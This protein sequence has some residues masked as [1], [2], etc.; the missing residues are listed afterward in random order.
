MK[1]IC[2]LIMVFLLLI[3]CALAECE[4]AISIDLLG[5]QRSRQP[6]QMTQVGELAAGGRQQF[7]LRL[8]QPESL[9]LC[10]P[11]A[12]APFN[13]T[14]LNARVNGRRLLPYFAFGG[15]T[16]YDA[17]KG[18][19]G[20]RP[21]LPTIEGRWVIPARWLRAD[22]NE[23]IIWTTGVQRDAALERLGPAPTIRIDGITIRPLDGANL[24]R[25][26]NSVYYDFGI[27][28]S[29]YPVGGTPERYNYDRA[30]LGMINGEGM[31]EL[32][33]PLDDQKSLWTTK[34]TC[35]DN[36]LGWGY[37]H[38]E[39]YTI[40]EFATKPQLWAKFIDV[41]K[42][43]E[44]TGELH[45]QTVGPE[46]T[47]PGAD[48]VLFDTE[49]YLASLEPAIRLLSPY[50]DFYDFKCEQ[51]GPRAHGFGK[52]GEKL[53]DNGIH[54]DMWAR[55]HYEANKA[56][57][58]LVR[59]YNPDDGFIQE[60][61]H[62]RQG[63]RP[64]LYD[65]ALKRGQPMGDLIDILSLSYDV[66]EENDRGPDGLSIPENGSFHLQYPSP[67]GLEDLPFRGDG[68]QGNRYPEV[69]ID[70][71]RYRLS[72]TEQ[73]MTLGDPKVNHWGN[74]R[75][76]D[77]RAGLR[78]DEMMYTS[79]NGVWWSGYCGSTTYQF[80]QGFFSY[81]L[82][83]TGA[84]EPR[85]MKITKRKSLLET[86][87]LE[88][89]RYGE[90]VNGAGNTKRLRTV[91]PLYGDLF[92]MTGQEM[93]GMRDGY[94]GSGF[95]SPN[96]RQPGTDAF[97]L[98]RRTCYAFMTTGPIVPVQANKGNSDQLFVKGL[99]QTFNYQTYIGIYA[100]N[101]G[102][103]A[104]TLNVTL[105]IAFPDGAEAIVYND[106]AWD[107]EASARPMSIPAGQEFRYTTKVPPLSA[108]LVLIPTSTD[109]LAA[110]CDLPAAPV[111]LSPEPDALLAKGRPTFQWK[112]GDERSAS[113]IVE[114]A[115]EAV[116]RPQDRVELAEGVK[117]GS[118]TLQADLPELWRYFWRVCAVDAQGRRGLWSV[119]RPF[120]YCW[121]EY[122]QAFPP[123]PITEP[124]A[125][126][127]RRPDDPGNLAWQGDV[128]GT[129]GVF[130]PS[131]HAIDMEE[132][133]Y[134]NNNFRNKEDDP[135]ILPAEWCVI[136]VRP[137][138]LRSVKI[139]WLEEQ[140][141]LEFAVQVSDDAKTWTDV[142]HRAD[143]IDMVTEFTLPQPVIA[144]FFRIYITRV[145]DAI[146]NVGIRE[147]FLQ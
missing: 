124:S 47:P 52:D 63:L 30:L 118:Y 10:V 98:V 146:G 103:K 38:Q 68:P 109:V 112:A 45:N 14:Q 111:V 76:F 86:I 37:G 28:S 21:P 144:S 85:D 71:N 79:E 27:W 15:D 123:K 55:N 105:P 40:W 18:K 54:G 81:S 88:V 102:D 60:M 83:P 17:V 5:A 97:G 131:S 104:E 96:H 43:P 128:Y 95:K 19:P 126:K 90:W 64:V 11:F 136:W 69:A 70:F 75:P 50:A 100:A 9:E 73:D 87:D 117:G 62:W 53:K 72:R 89:R 119:P 65:T 139:H 110:A 4:P 26:A 1:P 12:A 51:N 48:I 78:G 132:L 142:Y 143:D 92:G 135:C 20:M 133:S 138:A 42:N 137:T 80:L 44:T 115:R 94:G 116:F 91:D 145:S 32:Y 36:E 74:G 114:V 49:K 22:D 35:E 66:M 29:G 93:A 61:H 108:W 59:K 113:F 56:L 101:F 147:V 39:F 121:P 106:R 134:W 3:D 67:E 34:R 99:V 25:Y 82:L 13:G 31:A 84:G 140:L 125:P 46:L 129:G 7:L 2:N 107:W 16:R 24:P 41:D 58:D 127:A 6:V 8:S 141:P 77:Y 57:Y 33:V 130:H 122:A 120:I 23:V